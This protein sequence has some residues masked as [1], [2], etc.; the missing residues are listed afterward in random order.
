MIEVVGSKGLSNEVPRLLIKRL[1]I[2]LS[3]TSTVAKTQSLPEGEEGTG[4]EEWGPICYSFHQ[5]DKK[6]E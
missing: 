2:A 3:R 5:V 4:G 6:E 1:S